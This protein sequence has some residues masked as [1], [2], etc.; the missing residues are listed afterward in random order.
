MVADRRNV[1]RHLGIFAAIGGLIWIASAPPVK[2]QAGT[3]PQ[4]T[5]DGQLLA[6]V[7][8]ESWVFVGSNLGLAYKPDAPAT[9]AAEAARAEKQQFHNIYIKPEAYARFVATREF[10]D[11]TVLVMQK[12]VAADREPKGVLATGFFNGERA[13]LEVAV[14]NANRPDKQTTPWAYYDLTDPADPSKVRAS[15]RA[16]PDAACESCHRAHASTDNVWVQFYPTLRNA[17]N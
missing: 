16:F 8:F 15:A 5:P 11:L 2:G 9:T 3:A 10:P 6:P 7:R 13:G 17:S 12:F 4:Y 14:K 1:S